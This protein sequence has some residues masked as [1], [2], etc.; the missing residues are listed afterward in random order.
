MESLRL[1]PMN[2]Q[3]S[4]TDHDEKVNDVAGV[5]RTT[6]PRKKTAPA[7]SK[8]QRDKI[9]AGLFFHPN[10]IPRSLSQTFMDLQPDSALHVLYDLPTGDAATRSILKHALESLQNAEDHLIVPGSGMP[11][12]Y[13]RNLAVSRDIITSLD[14]PI[15]PRMVTVP[16]ADSALSSDAHINQQTFII[17]KTTTTGSM[18]TALESAKHDIQQALHQGY[19][20]NL[21][22]AMMQALLGPFLYGWCVIYKYVIPVEMIEML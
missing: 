15:R 1:A 4:E 2:G 10:Q 22:W 9:E 11:V 16:T 6:T 8:P 12:D 21:L 18:S 7:L 3:A 5:P 14:D 20:R 17:K 19:T 13:N